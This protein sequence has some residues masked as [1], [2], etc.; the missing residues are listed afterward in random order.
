MAAGTGNAGT[1][2]SGVKVALVIGS[3]WD[4]ASR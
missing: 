4:Y 3:S 1:E 2:P